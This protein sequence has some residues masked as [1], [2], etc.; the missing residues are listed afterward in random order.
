MIYAG[1]YNLA[2][3][4]DGKCLEI[5][6]TESGKSSMERD[7]GRYYITEEKYLSKCEETKYTIFKYCFGALCVLTP[8][9]IGFGIV[10]YI[11]YGD[12]Q[13]TIFKQKAIELKK[14]PKE[15]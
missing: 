12:A 11:W 13:G 5:S 1:Y 14:L 15:E 2:S 4:F 3:D 6:Q 7:M 9:H 8:F 10:L